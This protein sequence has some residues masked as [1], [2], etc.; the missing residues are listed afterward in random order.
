MKINI[1]VLVSVLALG[2]P[3]FQP[4][5]AVA[6]AAKPASVVNLMDFRNQLSQLQNDIS[7]TVSSLNTVKECKKEADLPKAV[8]ELG[9]RYTAL[10]ARVEEIRTNA[11]IVKAHVKAHFESWAKELTAMQSASLREKAQ[12][13]LSRSQKEFEK[14]IAEG[15]EA[16]EQVLPF[17]SEVKDIVIYLNADLSDDAVKTLSGNIWKLGN[18]SKS[19]IGSIGDVI[20]QIDDTVKSLPQT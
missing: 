3:L 5:Q 11:I 16:K 6:Q 10:E 12:D 2:A 17:V 15:V 18:R 8:K 19:V 4:Q 7:A 1:T 20:E 9:T 14:I 13:R